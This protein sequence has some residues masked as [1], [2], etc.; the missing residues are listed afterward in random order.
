VKWFVFVLVAT[1]F[2]AVSDPAAAKTVHGGSFVSVWQGKGVVVCKNTYSIQYRSYILG[3]R[4]A[5]SQV[6]SEGA[7]SSGTFAHDD[8]TWNFPDT[9][10]ALYSGDYWSSGHLVCRVLSYGRVRCWSTTISTQGFEIG[11]TYAE[12]MTFHA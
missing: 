8:G 6:A 10:T 11:K 7:Y 2:F 5:R 3:C 9:A 1:A 4:N 12:K